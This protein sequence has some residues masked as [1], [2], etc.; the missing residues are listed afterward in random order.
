MEAKGTHPL[1]IAIL[2]RTL[3]K[4]AWYGTFFSKL[5]GFSDFRNTN[6][7]E[8][9]RGAPNVVVQVVR[10]FIPQGRDNMI[11]PMLRPLVEP[12]VYGDAQLKGT[13][14]EL[15][16]KYME[17]MINAQRKAVVEQTGFMSNQ[18]LKLYDIAQ[19]A[20]PELVAWWSKVENQAVAESFYMGA[21]PNLTAGTNDQGIGLKK[22]FH[23]NTYYYAGSSVITAVG[24]E[25][26]TK[27]LT[28]ITTGITSQNVHKADA[29]FL[30]ELRVLC[31]SRLLIE[32]IMDVNG[33]P[34][35]VYLA[36]PRT[37]KALRQDTT[38]RAV[39]NSAFSTTKLDHEVIKGR[40]HFF[41]NGIA[42]VEA[43]IEVR[44]ISSGS[45]TPE[46]DLAA[47]DLRYG[48]MRPALQTTGY[49][50]GGIV[51]GRDA[52]AKGLAEP[53]KFTKEIDDHEAVVELGSRQIYG[54]NRADFFTE[55]DKPSVFSRNNAT[56]G[57][58]TSAYTATNQSSA[59]V[60]TED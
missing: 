5:A 21:S 27:I 43:D 20:M 25:Y 32:P 41:Y 18:R 47:G 17:V 7:N 40:N 29:G 54:Y 38:V 6:K 15:G 45:T 2:D 10:D 60:F 53:L 57:L 11:V 34:F 3:R 1:N 30:E 39:M 23:P 24:T 12:G 59:I 48:W 19:K 16:L 8:A 50:F 37:F 52:M 42:V 4:E 51:L 44:S 26:K 13:G 28:D 33:A 31:K 49:M 35:W 36:H 22:R 58:L 55:T 46:L 56:S 9:Y 14:E